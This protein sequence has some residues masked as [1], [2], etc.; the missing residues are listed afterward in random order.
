M[1]PMR[2]NVQPQKGRKEEKTWKAAMVEVEVLN[3]G[4]GDDAGSRD[5]IQRA[6]HTKTVV[7][8]QHHVLVDLGL[9]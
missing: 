2:H 6:K 8:Q 9:D 3:F 7:G 4:V 5:I 1:S